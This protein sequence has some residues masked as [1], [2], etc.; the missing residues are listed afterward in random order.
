MGA[1]R[2]PRDPV[3]HRG[4]RLHQTTLNIKHNKVDA[5]PGHGPPPNNT[6][7]DGSRS[8]N[9]TRPDRT[10]PDA[11]LLFFFTF[12]FN[13]SLFP[14]IAFESLCSSATCSGIACKKG[15]LLLIETLR[16]VRL[17]SCPLSLSLVVT[18]T[19]YRLCLCLCR[20]LP[21]LSA[22]CFDSVCH[23]HIS[24]LAQEKNKG[25]R[26]LVTPRAARF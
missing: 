10:R 21:F 2:D 16:T 12:F 26:P 18:T 25:K 13:S 1:P 17:Q 20:V 7:D 9:T 15:T 14:V 11:P 24:W 5:W 19:R 22:G 6:A 4:T 8:S 3:R 23:C